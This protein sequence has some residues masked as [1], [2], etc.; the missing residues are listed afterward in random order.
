[1]ASFCLQITRMLYGNIAVSFLWKVTDAKNFAVLLHK[2]DMRCLVKL[3]YDVNSNKFCHSTY[4]G[5]QSQPFSLR[6]GGIF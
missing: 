6:K 2:L 4:H 3:L 1:M 5:K